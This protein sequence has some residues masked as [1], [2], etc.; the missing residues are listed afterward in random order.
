MVLVVK[1]I[2]GIA[3]HSGVVWHLCSEPCHKARNGSG[4]SVERQRLQCMQ[5]LSTAAKQFSP[6]HT[7]FYL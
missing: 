2:A 3:W 6:V 5:T 7:A 1:N 4:M